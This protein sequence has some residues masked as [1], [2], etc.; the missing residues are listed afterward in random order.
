M[1]DYHLI[2]FML[3]WITLCH[4]Q[5]VAHYKDLYY[6]LFKWKEKLLHIDFITT[7]FHKKEQYK[8]IKSQGKMFGLED[9]IQLGGEEAGSEKKK[10]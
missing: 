5:T 8:R 7:K 9:W 1:I 10:G 4:Y 6:D 2:N 3:N